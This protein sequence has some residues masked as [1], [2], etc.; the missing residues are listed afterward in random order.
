MLSKDVNFRN[1]QG[2][3]KHQATETVHVG[4]SFKV[5]QEN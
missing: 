1:A 4:L 2:R 5:V 3:N